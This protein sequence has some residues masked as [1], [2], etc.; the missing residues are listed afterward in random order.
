MEKNDSL[1]K[2]AHTQR[3][4]G[5]RWTETDQ[6]N[7]AG[8][9]DAGKVILAG[10]LFYCSPAGAQPVKA[11]IR[12]GVSSSANAAQQAALEMRNRADAGEPGGRAG[13]QHDTA[14]SGVVDAS[15]DEF[16]HEG[17]FGH[18]VCRDGQEVVQ[19]LQKALGLDILLAVPGN[20]EEQRLHIGLEQCGLIDRSEERRV[21]KECRL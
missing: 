13:D 1:W 2:I 14:L 20:A 8:Q 12:S 17:G 19:E 6:A 11:A 7:G 5:T 10:V 18:I 15:A 9:K 4:S 3:S 16:P 21:G